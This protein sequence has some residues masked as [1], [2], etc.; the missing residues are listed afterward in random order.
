MENIIK[1]YTGKGS[2]L[3]QVAIDM[4]V[5]YSTLLR[6]LNKDDNYQ[7]N[8]TELVPFVKASKNYDLV[9]HINKELNLI[10]IPMMVDEDKFNIAG[11][12]KFT[13]ETGEALIE[14]S[15][16][17][18]DNKMKKDEAIKCRQELMDV[19]QCTWKLIKELDTIINPE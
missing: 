13:K 17:M 15:G 10:T 19:A 3:K 9:Y 4:D 11:I 12:A 16:A 14:L 18:A 8:I 5:P 2:N 1:T 6:K 7:L